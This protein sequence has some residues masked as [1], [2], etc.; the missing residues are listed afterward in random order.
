V[1][2]AY[3]QPASNSITFAY[4]LSTG[5]AIKVYV[6]NL[7]GTQIA[8]YEQAYVPAGTHSFVCDVS[9]YPPGMYFYIIKA[10]DSGTKFKAAK[11]MV[12]R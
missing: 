9:K 6:Y 7:M 8:V 11:F 10:T 12:E 1:P 3:P 5:S 2:I 4:A